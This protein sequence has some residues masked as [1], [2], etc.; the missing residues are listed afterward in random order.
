MKAFKLCLGV[1]KIGKDC[2]NALSIFAFQSVDCV[3]AILDGVHLALVII[4]RAGQRGNFKVKRLKRV[5]AFIQTVCK[6]AVVSSKRAT[7]E[8]PEAA[9]ADFL[10]RVSGQRFLRRV[11][12]SAICSAFLKRPGASEALLPHSF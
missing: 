8:R 10:R 12:A 4:K 3:N 1:I 2:R 9:R 5:I 11:T 7:E 6:L